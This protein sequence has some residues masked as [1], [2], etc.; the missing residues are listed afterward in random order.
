MDEVMI[1]VGCSNFEMMAYF[2]FWLGLAGLAGFIVGLV[3][4]KAF[5]SSRRWPYGHATQRLPGCH[6]KIQGLPE[7][8]LIWLAEST[9]SPI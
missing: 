2:I 7:K 3:L 6:V 4:T 8:V 9:G 5:L 1:I